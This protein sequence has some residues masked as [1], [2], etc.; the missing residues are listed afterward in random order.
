MNMNHLKK[1][2]KSRG[3]LAFAYNTPTT[4]YIDIA[5]KTLS[6][7]SKKLNLPYTL[8]TD[9]A[10]TQL[11]NQRFDIDL[12]IVADIQNNQE[13]ALK[14]RMYQR[15]VKIQKSPLHELAITGA[16]ANYLDVHI[17]EPGLEDD[18]DDE[19]GGGGN[20]IFNPSSVLYF[21]IILG[22]IIFII[23]LLFDIYIKRVKYKKKTLYLRYPHNY[24]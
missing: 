2:A 1:S 17:N 23:L 10:N 22:L 6:V 16:E 5:T 12:N 4:N 3:I 18:D 7:A 9:D 13:A 21:S 15:E 20:T 8:I 14:I 24:L 19:F 11:F